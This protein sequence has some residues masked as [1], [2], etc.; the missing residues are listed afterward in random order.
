ME[1]IQ[2]D[3]TLQEQEAAIV[4]AL[5]REDCNIDDL[6]FKNDNSVLR[7]AGVEV[8]VHYK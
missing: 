3:K 2:R 4:M 5:K 6:R 1:A 8:K 7:K